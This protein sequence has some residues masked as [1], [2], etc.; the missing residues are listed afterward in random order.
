MCNGASIPSLRRVG[1]AFLAVQEHVDPETHLLTF[2]LGYAED[3]RDDLD[4]E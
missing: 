2:A 3:G 4:R 1:I